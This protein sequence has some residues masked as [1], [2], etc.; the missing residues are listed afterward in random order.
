MAS[1][2]AE[3]TRAVAF[4]AVAVVGTVKVAEAAAN[5]VVDALVARTTNSA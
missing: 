2:E 4:V 5:A 1:L 3:A